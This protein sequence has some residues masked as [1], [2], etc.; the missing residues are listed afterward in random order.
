MENSEASS[1]HDSK[2]WYQS[3]ENTTLMPF[4]FITNGVSVLI[5]Y[6][7]KERS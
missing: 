7:N 6:L 1:L 4:P 2:V 3:L 5:S